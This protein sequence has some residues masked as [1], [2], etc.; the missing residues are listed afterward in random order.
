MSR[1]RAS[2]VGCRNIQRRYAFPLPPFRP[3]T[4]AANFS[5]ALFFAAALRS[6]YR[7]CFS[8]GVNASPDGGRPGGR[9]TYRA[10]TS[11]ARP[12]STTR[13]YSSG[14]KRRR[15]IPAVLLLG[16]CEVGEIAP[17]PCGL[18]LGL[19]IGYGLFQ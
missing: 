14:V 17:V 1:R 8:A 15:I 5:A 13:R 2:F 9:S 12:S 4:F 3:F 18:S 19:A 6:L 7:R 10:N 11:A 16:V